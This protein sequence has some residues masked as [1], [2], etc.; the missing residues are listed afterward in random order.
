MSS[1]YRHPFEGSQSGGAIGDKLYFYLTGTS[2]PQNTY[3]DADLATPHDN[4]VEA[5]AAGDFPP[6][7]LDP[8]LPAYRVDRKDINGVS[9]PGYPVD[10]YPSSQSQA[11]A[12]RAEGNNPQV[13]LYKSNGASGEKAW[14][15]AVIGNELKIQSGNDTE[16]SWTDLLVMPVGEAL[17]AS[18]S[19]TAT[20]SGV[21]GSV[22][23]TAYW[24]RTGNQ[25]T[26]AWPSLTGTSDGTTK[27]LSGI[28]VGLRP[29]AA[30]NALTTALDDA[31]GDREVVYAEFTVGS[32][33]VG[34]VRLPASATWTPTGTVIIDGFTSVYTI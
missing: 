32:G 5:D 23:G 31:P 24:V 6:I 21:S 27:T 8:S 22:T 34:L 1:L 10:D 33:S 14:R 2:T 16:D 29:A 18:G 11:P 9:Y 26:I 4:P 3:T 30:T 25:L 19:F 28:P 13:I 12:F 15:I 17:I 20:L 7:Y